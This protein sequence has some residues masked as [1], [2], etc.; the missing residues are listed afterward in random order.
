LNLALTLREPGLE[1]YV[2]RTLAVV[3]AWMNPTTTSAG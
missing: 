2:T 1:Q 3:T